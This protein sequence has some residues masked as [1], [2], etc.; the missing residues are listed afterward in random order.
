MKRTWNLNK[1]II[2]VENIAKEITWPIIIT[3]FG[4]GNK[5]K[6]SLRGQ[7]NRI[8]ILIHIRNT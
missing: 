7:C 3:S 4:H 6:R 5:Q 2:P 8:S 1:T